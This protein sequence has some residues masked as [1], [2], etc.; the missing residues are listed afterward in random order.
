MIYAGDGR[1]AIGAGT[2]NQNVAL[3]CSSTP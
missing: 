2:P 1:F 3:A